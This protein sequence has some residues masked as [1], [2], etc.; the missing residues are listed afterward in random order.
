MV[1]PDHFH[2][3]EASGLLGSVFSPDPRRVKTV[4]GEIAVFAFLHEEWAL[5]RN[6]RTSLF[7]MALGTH[8]VGVGARRNCQRRVW[9]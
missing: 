3:G 9:C 6:R 4:L 8:P 2:A 5:Q 1:A 7:L